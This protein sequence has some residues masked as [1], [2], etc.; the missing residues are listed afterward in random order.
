MHFT[1]QN[2]FFFLIIYTML[3]GFCDVLDT[4]FL[5]VEIA[6]DLGLRWMELFQAV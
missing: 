1:A 5:L 4:M 3:V 2:V 6:G